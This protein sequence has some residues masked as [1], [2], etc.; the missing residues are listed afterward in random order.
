MQRMTGSTAV[1]GKA[2][3]DKG[4]LMVRNVMGVLTLGALKA[5]GL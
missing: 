2:V 1:E 4:F 5:T 3:S